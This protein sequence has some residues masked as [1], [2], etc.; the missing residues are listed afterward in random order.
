MYD[1]VTTMACV[2][3]NGVPEIGVIH[4]PFTGQTAWVWV[5]NIASGYL[6]YL[7]ISRQPQRSINH[8]VVAVSRSHPGNAKLVAQDALGSEIKILTAAGAGYKVLQVVTNNASLYLH[9]TK[10]KKWDLCAGNAILREFGGNMITLK[11]QSIDYGTSTSPINTDGVLA[12]INNQDYYI[13]KF[14]QYINKHKGIVR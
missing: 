8:S 9:T 12:S 6:E 3:I 1:Y 13:S 7:R 10:I 11:N 5:G 4:R 14:M 2:A